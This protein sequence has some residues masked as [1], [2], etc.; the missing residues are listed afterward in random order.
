MGYSIVVQY[1]CT[2]CNGQTRKISIF[3][4]LNITI[5]MYW[6]LLNSFSYIEIYNYYIS[7]S[8]PAVLLWKVWMK[9]LLEVCPT[10]TVPGQIAF[11]R[12]GLAK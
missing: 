9:I 12:Q 11:L 2:L 7:C 8:Y 1:M 3:I 6:E 4:S 5:S 10:T